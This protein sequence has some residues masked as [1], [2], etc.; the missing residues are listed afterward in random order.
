[1]AKKKTT[2]Y[3]D[4]DLLRAAKVMAARNGVREYQILEDALRRYLGWEGIRNA[5]SRSDLSEDQAL[6]LAYEELHAARRSS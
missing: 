4:E 5:W 1:M 2:V 6:D 3:I